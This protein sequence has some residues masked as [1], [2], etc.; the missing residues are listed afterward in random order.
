MVTGYSLLLACAITVAI[1]LIIFPPSVQ[2]QTLDE[3]TMRF[4]YPGPTRYEREI[5]V[6]LTGGAIETPPARNRMLGNLVRVPP[7]TTGAVGPP[8]LPGSRHGSR[9]SGPS[10]LGGESNDDL[11][12]ALRHRRYDLPT[13]QSEELV[14]LALVKPEY[15]QVAIEQGLEG[16][17]ELLAL[18]DIRGEVQEVDIVRSAGHL[19]DGAAAAAVRR[20]RFKPYV[21]NGRIQA[22]YADFKFNFTLLDR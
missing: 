19:L 3:L 15:P 6:R 16:R 13:V 14:I 5:R 9:T 12:S 8:T 10:G 4:G 22:V 20:C 11:I 21:R 7:V 18:V 2:H 17:V 1:T